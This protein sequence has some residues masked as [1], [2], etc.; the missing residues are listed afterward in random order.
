MGVS[1]EHIIRTLNE[2]YADCDTIFTSDVGQH[3]MWASQYL[4][5]DETHRLVQSGGLGTMG[6]GLPS[7]VGAKIGCPEKEV[8]SI[9]GDGGFQMNIQEM[10]TAVNQEL[11]LVNIVFIMVRR[12]SL[13]LQSE[14]S[15]LNRYRI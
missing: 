5:L 6:F 1:P 10:A 11:P 4:K 3:Q 13:I 8:V 2:V 7:A 9:S 15:F 14:R 12:S